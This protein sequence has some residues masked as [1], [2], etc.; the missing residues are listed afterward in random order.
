MTMT[1]ESMT[2]VHGQPIE[3]RHTVATPTHPEPVQRNAE[4]VPGG[5]LDLI[6]RVP[7]LPELQEG[8]LGQIFRI[9]AAPRDEVESLVRTFVFFLDERVET[10]PC[11]DTFSRGCSR[12]PSLLARHMDA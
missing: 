4:E 12:P 8:I 7:P 2:V 10:G 5:V 3:G 11:I 1:L 9:L 6:D